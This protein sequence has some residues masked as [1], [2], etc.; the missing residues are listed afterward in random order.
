ME[1][2]ECPDPCEEQ[3]E[4]EGKKQGSYESHSLLFLLGYAHSAG[5]AIAADAPRRFRFSKMEVAA[6]SD[7]ARTNVTVVVVA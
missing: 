1:N 6:A 7:A 3:Y 2:D 4:R 5:T